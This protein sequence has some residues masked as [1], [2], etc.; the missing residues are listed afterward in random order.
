MLK[1]ARFLAAVRLPFPMAMGL[2]TMRHSLQ[3]L[4]QANKGITKDGLTVRQEQFA[5]L[6]AKGDSLAD[7]YRKAYTA[8]GK[9]TT[10]H[11]AASALMGNI[12]VHSRIE[13]LLKDIESHMHR[14]AVTIRRHVFA[15]LMKESRNDK[16]KPSERIAALIALGKIDVVSMFR[17]MPPDRTVSERDPQ[18]IELELRDRLRDLFHASD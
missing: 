17:E 2:R 6:V 18:V 7:A 15:G 12:K 8:K 13:A 1:T 14:D 10:V 5:Q 11:R 9:T 3:S 4:V 16:A